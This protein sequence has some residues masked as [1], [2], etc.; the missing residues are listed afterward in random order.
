MTQ[1]NKSYSDWLVVSDIDGTLNNKF[2]KLPKRNFD[3][4]YRFVNE[5]GGNFTLASGRSVP[6]L[7]PHYNKLPARK[8]PAIISNGAGIYDFEKQKMIF[9]SPINPEG[10]DIVIQT[11]VKFP[12]ADVIIAGLD[13][14]MVVGKGYYGKMIPKADNIEYDS[15]SSFK[16]VKKDD[17]GKV[18][19]IGQPWVIAQVGKYLTGLNSS[20]ITLMSTSVASFEVLNK[21]TNKGT[22][23]LHLADTMGIDHSHTAAIGDYFNDLDMI[24]LVGVSACC[25]QAPKALK[26]SAEF[27]ACHCNKGAVADLLEYIERTYQ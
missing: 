7:M 20:E 18:V 13:K 16:D 1:A 11:A 22:A 25:G 26:E 27:V 15:Y 14:L 8:I 6:S 12:Q 9:F 4:I 17:W 24:K 10:V 2:R 3:A 23:V 5:L 21:N 19:F